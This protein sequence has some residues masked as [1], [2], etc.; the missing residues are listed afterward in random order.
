MK[1]LISLCMI[2][3]DESQSIR[4]V[5]ETVKPFIDCYTIVDTGSTDGTQEIVREAMVGVPGELHN[6]EFIDF[7]QARN[8]VL[9]LDAKRQDA[10]VFQLILSGDEYLFA[11]AALR[12][13]LETQRETVTS[14]FKLR[15]L[16]DDTNIPATRVIRTGSPWRYKRRVHEFLAWYGEGEAP[17]VER[18]PD[19]MIEHE[20]ADPEKRFTA[21]WDKHIPL[22]K[23]EL[24]EDPNDTHALVY[25]AHSYET[26]FSFINSSERITY[27]ME[28]MSLYMR[29]LL[30]PVASDAERNYL[31]MKFLDVSRWAG[32]F[33]DEELL[34][35]CGELAKDDPHRP[36]TALL[37]V[38]A[39]LKTLPRIQVFEL[40]VRA[41]QIAAE[42]AKMTDVSSPVSTACGW[43]AHYIAAK[44]AKELSVKYPDQVLPD[45]KMFKDLMHEQATAGIRAGGS[46]EFFKSITAAEPELPSL[47]SPSVVESAQ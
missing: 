28:A 21:V 20:V 11:G 3:R 22:L 33:T 26:L 12:Q 8:N 35:R 6:G 29:R 24:A 14:C 47:A 1:P 5:L 16:L 9:D 4:R 18:I 30:L 7:S 44:T 31:R 34:A 40:A 19:A 2:L 41:A 42:A 27:A 38:N 37:L 39:A 36:E 17:S 10:A 13:Y 45:G 46:W 32:V 15:L 25:L 23:E 43:K